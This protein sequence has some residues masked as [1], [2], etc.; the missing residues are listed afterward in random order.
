MLDPKKVREALAETEK[1]EIISKADLL[2]TG[3]ALL[4]LA[5]TNRVE[6]G[7][8]KGHF[9]FIVGDSFSGKT[10]LSLTCLAEASINPFFDDYR[11][12]YDGSERG[13]LMDIEKFF[14]KKVAE[15]IE[16]P[17]EDES[18]PVYSYTIE[19][20]YYHVDDA[21][22]G[23]KPFIYILDS[24]DALSS[25]S[26][27]EKF[28]KT[29]EAYRSGKAIAGSYGDGKAKV[30]SSNL[31]KLIGPLHDTKSILIILNQTRD[32][33]GFGFNKKTRSGGHAL[34]FYSTI[35]LWSSVK[36]RLEKQINGKK[37]QVGIN[38]KIVIKKNRITGKDTVIE[39]PIYNS[40][41]I[42]DIGSCIDFLVDEGVWNKKGKGIVCDRLGPTIEGPV[43]KV[44]KEIEEKE[45]VEDF[46]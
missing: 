16:P 6:G 22:L 3:S 37:R 44:I 25:E 8:V 29:K 30:N 18:G 20:F 15:R 1:K 36:G 39:I 38:C 45:L 5:C 31:R 43:E 34:K 13:A 42:D 28:D 7:F 32:D 14:G 24:M 46:T 11:F 12:I 27:G 17:E 23:E 19:E 4:N 33:I 26:E 40:Y 41:G 35:E 10:F 9:F 2:S 21:L